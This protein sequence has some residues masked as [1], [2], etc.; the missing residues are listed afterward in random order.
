MTSKIVQL[1]SHEPLQEAW[2]TRSFDPAGRLLQRD[3]SV[4]Q[5]QIDEN[6]HPVRVVSQLAPTDELSPAA[7]YNYADTKRVTTYA[8]RVDFDDEDA[9]ARLLRDRADEVVGVFADPEVAPC[10]LPYC[11][12][13]PVGT[14]R[15]V[16]TGL[17]V[18]ALRTAGLNGNGVRVAVV[19]TGIDGQLVPVSGGWT[20]DP[21][22]RPGQ[23]ARDHGSMVAFDVTIAAP[24]AQILDYAALSRVGLATLLSNVLAAHTE[25][26][27]LIQQT[28]G[29]LVINNS[30]AVYRRGADEPIGS[31]GNYSANMNHPFNQILS[32]LVGA[33][34]D[35][36]FAAGNCGAECPDG[37]CGVTDI[38]PGASIHGGN[39][40]PDI[41]SIAA[42]TTRHERLGYS[43]QG[44]GGLYNRKPDLSAYSHFS[45]SG[46]FPADSGTSAAS[47]VAAGVVAAIRQRFSP[48]QLP[49]AQL[50]GALQ[51]SAR[52]L[53]GQG[54]SYDFGYGVINAR[55]ALRMLGV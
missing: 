33:G 13:P 17:S 52:D 26:L 25:L 53:S 40:H 46:V 5:M 14:T 2:R 54:W 55:R 23:F 42:V 8:I 49:P 28:P 16:Q 31:P 21:A 12:A 22:D 27:A 38:G 50:K 24:R 30:W 3:V 36:L 29:P 41:L 43:S 34:A 37:R 11:G 7:G 45:G 47:P 35:I 1:R 19:D 9:V 51:R 10:P 15:G 6:Y 4:T 20:L 39:S 44:P 32:T 48:A 18:S